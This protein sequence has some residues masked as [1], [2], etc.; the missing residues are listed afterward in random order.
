MN[1]TINNN[2]YYCGTDATTQ[3][4]GQ[5]GTT[6]SAPTYLTLAALKVYTGTLNVAGTNDNCHRKI[7][8]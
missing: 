6:A 8:L 1:L 2:A 3:G 4:I 7:Q 5:A